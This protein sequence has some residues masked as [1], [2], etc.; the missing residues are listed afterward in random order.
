VGYL[1]AI[2]FLPV[3]GAILIALIP[4]QSDRVTRRIAAV[5][6]FIPLA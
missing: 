6:T 3:I 5:V 1:N 2:I 4:G